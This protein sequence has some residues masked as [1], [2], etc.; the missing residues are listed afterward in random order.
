MIESVFRRDRA[1]VIACLAGISV[2]AWIYLLRMP[3]PMAGMEGMADMAPA[4]Y[5]EFAVAFAMWT[6][7]MVGMMVT[8]AAPMILLF[9]KI[10]RTRRAASQPY[11][12]T[13]IFVFG[14]L[15]VW[16][17]ASLA[18]AGAQ[19]GLA[20]ASMLSP[21]IGFLSPAASGAV[22]VGAGLYQWSPWKRACLRRCRSPLDFLLFHWRDGAAGAL[23]MGIEHG[24]YCL[25]CCWL[26][27][28]LLFVAGVMNLG[29]VAA[30]MV[31]VLLEKTAPF[32]P[33]IARA[34]GGAFIGAGLYLILRASGL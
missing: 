18:A 31:F 25:G 21:G 9:A 27:M 34:S 29:Y 6:V 8:P 24:L 16:A 15:I 11:V 20:R 3:M 30:L 4:G 1:I 7:M 32:G 14:Y 13:L 23:G 5:P 22:L 10:A 26:L 17:A 19:I 12:P 2:L 28:A 33:W